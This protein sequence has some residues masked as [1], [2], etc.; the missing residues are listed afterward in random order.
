MSWK[1]EKYLENK[2]I[3]YRQ[4]LMAAMAT[5]DDLEFN[6]LIW[7]TLEMEK[8]LEGILEGRYKRHKAQPIDNVPQY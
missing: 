6:A 1:L 7:P 3:G 5:G 2:L 8:D 4:D